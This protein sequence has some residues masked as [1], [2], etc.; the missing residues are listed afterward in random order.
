MA[1]AHGQQ[2][3][4]CWLTTDCEL[5]QF[6]RRCPEVVLGKFVAV[7]SIDSGE[8]WLTEVDERRGW[9]CRGGIGYSP[10]IQRVSWLPNA[11]D[12]GHCRWFH[13]WYV[14]PERRELGALDRE[15]NMFEALL[16]PGRVFALVNYGGFDLGDEK[17][18]GDY[19]WRQ[20]AWIQPESYLADS[21]IS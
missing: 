12:L 8:Y 14:F 9:T 15:S 5:P 21:D 6:L 13:E 2:G 3:D 4:Y 10:P 7:T 19:F 20:M 16:E 18:L 1:L 17:G 11:R